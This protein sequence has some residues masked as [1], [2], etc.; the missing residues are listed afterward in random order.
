M[1]L[2]AVVGPVLLLAFGGTIAHGAGFFAASS[3]AEAAG[4][5]AGE[6]SGAPGADVEADVLCDGD[7]G[8][9]ASLDVDAVQRRGNEGRAVFEVDADAL[10]SGVRI[11]GEAIEVGPEVC[12]TE[13]AELFRLDARLLFLVRTHPAAVGV[14]PDEDVELEPDGGA[15][16][17]VEAQLKAAWRAVDDDGSGDV[18][19]PGLLLASLDGELDGKGAEERAVAGSEGLDAVATAQRLVREAGGVGKVLR[20]HCV[21]RGTR[22][23]GQHGQSV[24]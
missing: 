18:D 23:K 24:H 7:F 9:V 19:A 22:Q 4:Q 11:R 14:G 2:A 20:D 8:E 1:E 17:E 15:R 10:A 6:A 16:A 5:H 13:L 12:G 3:L 21:C